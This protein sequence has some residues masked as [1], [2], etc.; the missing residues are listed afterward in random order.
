MGT[1]PVFILSIM[2]MHH[3]PMPSVFLGPL[4]AYLLA[5]Y[6]HESSRI[7]PGCDSAPES[8]TRASDLLSRVCYETRIHLAI[9]RIVFTFGH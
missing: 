7:S 6:D 4:R 8:G 5:P 2:G 3:S 9:Y 1:S